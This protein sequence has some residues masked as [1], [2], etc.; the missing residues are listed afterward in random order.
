MNP[1]VT[2]L[3]ETFTG[4]ASPLL[5]LFTETSVVGAQTWRCSNFG[6]NDTDAVYMNGYA[7]GMTNDNEDWLVSPCLRYVSNDSALLTFLE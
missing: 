5:G 1:P 6:H 4:C 7:G 2:S 3:N